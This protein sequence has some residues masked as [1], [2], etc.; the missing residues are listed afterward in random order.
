[1]NLTIVIR[2][3]CNI[4]DS[5]L[6]ALKSDTV[7]YE[8]ILVES[9]I[10]TY[11][12]CD[13][14]EKYKCFHL[15][16][17]ESYSQRMFEALESIY[18]GDVIAFLDNDVIPCENWI[19]E[20]YYTHIKYPNA[21]FVGGPVNIRTKEQDIREVAQRKW[22][23]QLVNRSVL[24]NNGNIITSVPTQVLVHANLSVKAIDLW[25]I[26]KQNIRI[27]KIGQS[28]YIGDGCYYID[29][30]NSIFNERMS[31]TYET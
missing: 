30:E 1:M 29:D 22:P 14:A 16:V 7:N 17:E 3:V 19:N 24:Y 11:N 20:A 31:V 2:D 5:V 18:R 8:I 28:D 12:A 4:T 15:V 13:L 26:G 27:G 21:K 9:P 6:K 25:K 23:I 10:F